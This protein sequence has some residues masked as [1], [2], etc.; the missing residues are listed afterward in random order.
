LQKLANDTLVKNEFKVETNLDIL[1]QSFWVHENE[2]K[3]RMSQLVLTVAIAATSNGQTDTEVFS[4]RRKKI[5]EKDFVFDEGAFDKHLQKKHPQTKIAKTVLD[6]NLPNCIFNFDL[7]SVRAL[8]APSIE[9]GILDK[10]VSKYL[11]QAFQVYQTVAVS[12]V[13]PQSNPQQLERKIMQLFTELMVDRSYALNLPDEDL[14]AMRDYYFT[15]FYRERDELQ[16]VGPNAEVAWQIV[17][18]LIGYHI[19]SITSIGALNE[20]EIGAIL[21]LPKKSGIAFCA[22]QLRLA[23]I[24]TDESQTM[25]YFQMALV[26]DAEFVRYF[27]TKLIK[28]FLPNLP[29]F[30]ENATDDILEEYFLQHVVGFVRRQ[31]PQIPIA[32][33]SESAVAPA[34]VAPKIAFLQPSPQQNPK[35]TGDPNQVIYST[36][37][38]DPS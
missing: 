30:V 33:M 7:N 22:H 2:L 27:L 37:P 20:T 23:I 13:I 15:N 3:T 6:L 14:N 35:P 16:E 8:L 21:A 12:K 9:N 1:Q 29:S 19:L 10:N 26:E 4:K 34:N 11:V 18:I 31:L 28:D 5:D 32:V 17:E 24:D 38:S 25:K 36:F